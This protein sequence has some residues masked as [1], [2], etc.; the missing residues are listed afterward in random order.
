MVEMSEDEQ[1]RQRIMGTHIIELVK[2]VKKRVWSGKEWCLSECARD[3]GE[4]AVS[5]LRVSLP[6]FLSGFPQVVKVALS[7]HWYLVY[8]AITN[9]G[10]RVV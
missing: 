8:Q 9:K 1:M 10:M 5:L 6:L 7:Q 3:I 2:R 4:T